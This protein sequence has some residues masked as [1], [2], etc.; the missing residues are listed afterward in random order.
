MSEFGER[1]T[2]P[3]IIIMLSRVM[4]VIRCQS[5]AS[6][7]TH[8]WFQREEF[9]L[10]C[11]CAC[12]RY[13]NR[14]NSILS[15][16]HDVCVFASRFECHASSGDTMR[17]AL[18]TNPSRRSYHT[19]DACNHTGILRKSH[20]Q[21]RIIFTHANIIMCVRSEYCLPACRMSDTVGLSFDITL[22][23]SANVVPG[24]LVNFD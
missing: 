17:N 16:Y 12:C 19:C 24:I 23:L 3:N 14:I 5:C 1:A 6:H 18:C 13:I 2:T 4:N 10:A 9:L 15:N 20:T 7:S 8:I 21:L 11:V 22:L